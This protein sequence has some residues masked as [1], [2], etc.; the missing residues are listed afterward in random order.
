[1]ADDARFEEVLAEILQAEEAGRTPDLTA[2]C[3]RFPRLAERLR[4]Y[5]RDRDGFARLARAIAP[6]P[7]Q[8]T[9]TGYETVTESGPAA[10]ATGAVGRYR[11]LEEVGRGG[12]GVV[13]RAEDPRL[14]RTVALK[15]MLPQY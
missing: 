7:S 10:P 5:F 3:E 9:T 11:L 14:Q 15:V 1:M 6:T 4:A 8:G 2:Y 13:Y 12:M